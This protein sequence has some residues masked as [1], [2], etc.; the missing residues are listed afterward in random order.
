MYYYIYILYKQLS[1]YCSNWFNMDSNSIRRYNIKVQK[2]FTSKKCRPR[3]LL[4]RAYG[5]YT[6]NESKAIKSLNYIITDEKRRSRL[7]KSVSYAHSPV[8]R[9]SE[10]IQF[11]SFIREWIFKE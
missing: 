11:C 10:D 7:G 8:K 3:S 4:T 9:Q 5:P 6:E 2:H 1:L